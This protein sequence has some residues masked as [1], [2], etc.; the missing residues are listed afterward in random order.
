VASGTRFEHAATERAPSASVYKLFVALA[1]LERVD[2]AELSL[3]DELTI[4][5]VD[6]LEDGAESV[7]ERLTVRQAL[8]T[9]MGASSNR[10]AFA[11]LRLVGRARMNARL[12]ELG[13]RQSTVPLLIGQ[14]PL[15]GSPPLDRQYAVSAPADLA[16]LLRLIAAGQTLSPASRAAMRDL[17]ALDEE[18]EPLR[19]ALAPSAVFAKNGWLP[20]VRNVAALL[21][22]PTGPVV[23]AAFVEA[24]SDD[25]AHARIVQIGRALGQLYGV[26]SRP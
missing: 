1:V 15:P 11:L 20:G 4:E 2:R 25:A 6:A 8:A 22:T 17:L 19:D 5:A 3:D 13:L 23:V 7:G 9:M 10:S 24:D 16:G 18:I 14:S 21:D 12:V 26:P